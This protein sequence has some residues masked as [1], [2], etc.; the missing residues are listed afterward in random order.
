MIDPEVRLACLKIAAADYREHMR[1]EKFAGNPTN[2]IDVQAR[3]DRYYTYV[4]QNREELRLRAPD[5]HAMPP[6]I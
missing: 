3:A 1:K 2:T 6:G 4:T 5:Y